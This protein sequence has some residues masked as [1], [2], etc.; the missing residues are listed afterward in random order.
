MTLD[1]VLT[2]IQAGYTKEEISQLAA[3]PAEPETGKSVEI[4]VP[5]KK[6]ETEPKP[7][8][9]KKQPEISIDYAKM[10][11]ELLKAMAGQDNGTW[12]P[13]KTKEEKTEEAL[14]SLLK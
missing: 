4:E 8:E 2:L 6:P 1:Q 10:S 7:A 12:T 3:G 14:L 9:E 5:E 13:P 11:K